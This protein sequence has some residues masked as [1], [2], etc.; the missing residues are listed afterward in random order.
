MTIQIIPQENA[1][2][3]VST[4]AVGFDNLTID[5]IN[6]MF[7]PIVF[8]RVGFTQASVRNLLIPCIA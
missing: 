2:G 7:V 6:T 5:E 1:Q 4:F 8:S 3:N